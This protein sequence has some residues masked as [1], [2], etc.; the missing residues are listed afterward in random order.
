MLRFVGRMEWRGRM[1]SAWPDALLTARAPSMSLALQVCQQWAR[2]GTGRQRQSSLL[3]G[4]LA[5]KQTVP[6]TC[7]CTKGSV[8][9]HR[10][11][12]VCSFLLLSTIFMAGTPGLAQCL[13]EQQR[14]FGTSSLISLPWEKHEV[15]SL[16]I[17]C[18]RKIKSKPFLCFWSFCYKLLLYWRVCMLL[19]IKLQISVLGGLRKDA[20][21]PLESLR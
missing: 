3:E 21:A 13:S 12:A 10:E 16:K 2:L 15:F 18:K 9:Q 5:Q 14:R 8:Y 4:C 7:T 6:H 20:K 1:W 11:N 17:R 19:N